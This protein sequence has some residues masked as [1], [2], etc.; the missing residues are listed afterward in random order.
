M[1]ERVHRRAMKICKK[2]GER[3][4]NRACSDRTS[5]G[6]RLD[7]RK[8]F[9]TTRVVKHWHRLPR[10]MVDAPSLETFKVRLG[11]AL[12]NMI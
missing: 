2:D 4:F 9:I 10:E 5:C 3:L 7:I 1:L 8:T 11:R 12:R 6:L